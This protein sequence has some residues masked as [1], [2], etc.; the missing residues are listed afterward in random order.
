MK[1]SQLKNSLVNCDVDFIINLLIEEL[2]KTDKLQ[3]NLKEMDRLFKILED[4]NKQL[5]D[6]LS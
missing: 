3:A 6:T 2:E 1:F 4:E 5:K